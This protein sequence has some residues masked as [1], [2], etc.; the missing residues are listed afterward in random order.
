MKIYNLSQE[1]QNRIMKREFD[2]VIII[3]GYDGIAPDYTRDQVGVV[4]EIRPEKSDRQEMPISAC[5]LVAIL[6]SVSTE[7]RTSL[8]P[9]F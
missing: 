2:K 1:T 8:T 4:R 5:C 6:N 7:K 9:G 3:A